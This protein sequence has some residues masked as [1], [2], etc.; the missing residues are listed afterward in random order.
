MLGVCFLESFIRGLFIQEFVV[1]FRKDKKLSLKF[2]YP[3]QDVVVPHLCS[4]TYST[5]PLQVLLVKD[6]APLAILN[7]GN[8]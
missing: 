8:V 1:R 2:S 4:F 5:M 6:I 3:L 7:N